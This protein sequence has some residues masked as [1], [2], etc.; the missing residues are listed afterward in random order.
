MSALRDAIAAA[1]GDWD[2]PLVEERIFGT[3]SVTDIADEIEHCV[4]SVLGSPVAAVHAY[5]A[6]VGATAVVGL[7]DGRDIAIKVHQPCVPGHYLEAVHVLHGHLHRSRFPCARP[8]HGPTGCGLGQATFS[9][10]VRLPEPSSVVDPIS[11]MAALARLASYCD[12]PERFGAEPSALLANPLLET[13][14]GLPYPQPH[15]PAI[16]FGRIGSRRPDQFALTVRPVL[17]ADD[18]PR[19]VTH[20]DWSPRNVFGDRAGVA[21][22]LDLDSLTRCSPGRAAGMAAATWAIDTADRRAVGAG[23]GM[24]EH[25][26]GIFQRVHDARFDAAALRVFWAAA[27]TRACYLARCETAVGEP[28]AASSTVEQIGEQMLVRALGSA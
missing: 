12:T 4:R 5:H 15:H 14:V 17:E 3:R 26:G 23:I 20:A 8:L 28:G 2:G 11:S 1:W 7:A 16:S 25:L 13:A 27:L 19:V 10:R 9:E 21:M 22:V 24:L 18:G 6:S